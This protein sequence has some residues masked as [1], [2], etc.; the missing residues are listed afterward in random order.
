[1]RGSVEEQSDQTEVAPGLRHNHAR[2]IGQEV[3]G[4][5][6]GRSA[7]QKGAPTETVEEC[8][9]PAQELKR[10]A[11]PGGKK[12]HHEGPQ[13]L[14]WF[15]CMRCHGRWERSTLQQNRN[16]VLADADTIDFQCAHF[17][18]TYLETF[19]GHQGFCHTILAIINQEGLAA[20]DPGLRRFGRY[21]LMKMDHGL[22]LD[23]IPPKGTPQTA[24]N[25]A[26]FKEVDKTEYPAE[27]G[28][29]EQEPGLDPA[30]DQWCEPQMMSEDDV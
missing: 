14:Y 28:A 26:T 5:F 17:G 27:W 16:E 18:A 12:S 19:H 11:C 21:L 7:H 2:I 8:S 20:P 6:L 25:L 10:R 13:V 22:L 9:H 23:L 15:T 24:E 3:M 1:M 4:K 29:I 30:I